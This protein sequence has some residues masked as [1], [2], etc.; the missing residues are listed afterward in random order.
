MRYGSAPWRT[1]IFS[2]LRRS[3][4]HEE[5]TEFFLCNLHN[6]RGERRGSSLRE[7]RISRESDGSKERY[8]LHFCVALMWQTKKKPEKG[9]GIRRHSKARFV[10][11]LILLKDFEKRLSEMQI[12]HYKLSSPPFGFPNFG[13][14]IGRRSEIK[15]EKGKKGR[16]AT[17]KYRD[18][19]VAN[20]L[21]TT[22]V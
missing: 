13:A 7:F 14:R 6:K 4:H 2:L 1:A 19:F 11:I 15:G 20:P 16:A 12:K 17:T 8:S 3:G 10:P 9:S 18:N 21:T 22:K 5:K